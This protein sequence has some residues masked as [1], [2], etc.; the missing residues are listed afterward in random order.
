MK[1]AF[2][3]CVPLVISGVCCSPG[4]P[5]QP[6]AEAKNEEAA[7]QGY[8]EATEISKHREP[9]PEDVGDAIIGKAVCDTKLQNGPSGEGRLSL[10]LHKTGNLNGT[11]SFTNNSFSLTGI[12]EG[13]HLRIWASVEGDDALGVRHGFLFGSAQNGDYEGFFALSGNGG[14]PRLEGA[15]SAS[16]EWSR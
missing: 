13:D 8:G 4:N 15:W 7:K 16:A 2:V 14:E 5:E 6:A 1:W 11:L 9:L 3:L 10:I 12:K